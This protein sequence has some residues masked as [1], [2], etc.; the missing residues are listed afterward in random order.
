MVLRTAS[1]ST[2]NQ[3]EVKL[4]KSS[5]DLLPIDHLQWV[6]HLIEVLLKIFLGIRQL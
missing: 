1:Q 2:S 3:V 5:Q 6:D 4:I